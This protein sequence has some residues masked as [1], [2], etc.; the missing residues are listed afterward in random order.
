MRRNFL[1]DRRSQIRAALLSS[2]TVLILLV[3]LNLSLYSSRQRAND[4]VLANAPQLAQML[5][6]QSRLETVLLL[7]SS[8]VLLVGVFVVTI[9]ETHKTAGA[10]FNVQRHLERVRLGEYQTRVRLRQDDTLLHVGETFNAMTRALES[11]T[12]SEVEALER[13]AERAERLTGPNDAEDLGRELR[14]YADQL[15]TRVH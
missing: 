11:R 10:A 4:Q 6:S 7:T 14:A 8:L 2:G 3:L 1:I 5:E 9:L 13:F 15:R 12:W